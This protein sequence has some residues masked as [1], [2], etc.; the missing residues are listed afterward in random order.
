[1]E[2][3]NLASALPPQ[4]SP[5]VTPVANLQP[6]NL[7]PVEP[8][9]SS[10][11]STVVTILLL[12][13]VF[14]IGVIVMWMWPKW[15]KSI[16]ILLTVLLALGILGA[17]ILKAMNPIKPLPT[18]TVNTVGNNAGSLPSMQVYNDPAEWSITYDPKQVSSPQ[19]QA[20]AVG[21]RVS[22]TLAPSNLM[23]MDL[24][25]LV[26][27][28]SQ[29]L[30]LNQYLAA[31]NIPSASLTS[32]TLNGSNGLSFTNTSTVIN[33][34]VPFNQTDHTLYFAKGNKVITLGYGNGNAPHIKN[35]AD[36]CAK[37]EVLV[38]GLI[39]GFKIN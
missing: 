2:E 1:M 14:P 3:N 31:Q 22:L 35:A 34:G 13:F 21:G 32:V 24:S 7:N 26:N 6:N 18:R 30:P 5:P 28:N 17:F 39:N 15:P 20:G 16:K 33:N 9:K 37:S 11:L 29:N 12:I 36:D 10:A 4:Q 23:C 19:H 38:K 25:I 8:K 27:D